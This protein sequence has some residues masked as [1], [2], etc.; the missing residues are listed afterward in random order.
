M[1]ILSSYIYI[2][3][4]TITY[5]IILCYGYFGYSTVHY[6]YW[7]ALLV[8]RYLSNTASFVLCEIRRDK[9]N[10]NLLHDSPLLK[11]TCVRRVVLDKR[12]LLRIAI[13]SKTKQLF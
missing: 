7:V 5:Y 9:D 13:Y 2:L 6:K 10:S 12:F 3:Y 4:H 8:L 1:Y 11:K